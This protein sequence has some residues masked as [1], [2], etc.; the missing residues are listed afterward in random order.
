ML[1]KF[2]SFVVSMVGTARYKAVLVSCIALALS[3]TGITA[4]IF[5]GD[6]PAK[7]ASS[8][9]QQ[10]KDK[11]GTSAFTPQLRGQKQQ[12]KDQPPDDTPASAPNQTS[13]STS[14]NSSSTAAGIPQ[15]SATNF[16]FTL[17]RTPTTLA[18]DSTSD[19]ISLTT[20]DNSSVSWQVTSSNA[21]VHILS[22]ASNS[23]TTT[24]QLQAA[25]SLDSGTQIQITVTA[26]DAARNIDKPKSFTIVIQ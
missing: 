7:D 21:N 26:H 23:A 15:Q 3:F 17:G 18:A 8:T 20:N 19:P 6:S 13:S 4:L 14:T 16:D 9:V 10:S 5:R 25:K 1:V 11:T 22:A 12:A 24:F 2:L